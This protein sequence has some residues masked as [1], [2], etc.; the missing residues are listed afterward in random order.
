MPYGGGGFT[1]AGK[2]NA[3]C[4]IK[5]N[6]YC[7]L[8][9]QFRLSFQT[10]RFSAASLLLLLFLAHVVRATVV[11]FQEGGLQQMLMVMPWL[12]NASAVIIA[13]V[14]FAS[15]SANSSMSYPYS[16]FVLRIHAGRVFPEQD[17]LRG[18][19]Q[20]GC[21]R[22]GGEGARGDP[23]PARNNSGPRNAVADF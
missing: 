18:V 3:R 10:A 15:L 2:I 17:P 21:L 8:F 5:A 19:H 7:Y 23:A 1:S 9:L 14:M 16:P 20:Q 11:D 22:L 13:M 12:A 6:K 4:I